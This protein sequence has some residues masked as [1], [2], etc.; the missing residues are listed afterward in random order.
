MRRKSFWTLGLVVCLGLAIAGFADHKGK[1][2]GKGG[3]TIPV[4][5]TFR[6][7]GANFFVSDPDRIMSDCQLGDTAD[8]GCPYDDAEKGVKVNIDGLHFNL[9][10][11]T[12]RKAPV[13]AWTLD[14]SE[15]LSGANC[16]H[17]FVN[18]PGEVG[19]VSDAVF[20]RSDGTVGQLP[21]GEVNG[22]LRLS[23]FVTALVDPEDMVEKQW[24]VSFKVRSGLDDTPCFTMM[25][26]G[27]LATHPD[28][29]TWEFEACPTDVACLES[30]DKGNAPREFRG[31]YHMPFL[32]TAVR[33]P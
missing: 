33:K 19:T 28:A 16:R 18:N 4:T 27:I 12:N 32:I 7:A 13:R 17:P 31:L 2:H 29:D 26:S 22:D 10:L 25:T 3:G 5:V 15:C 21:V 30:R 14:F 8:P 9:E 11:T 6:D 23:F 1:P 24:F 20:V